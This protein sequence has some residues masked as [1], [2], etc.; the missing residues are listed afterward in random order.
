MHVVLFSHEINFWAIFVFFQ[1]F[2][3]FDGQ[4]NGKT[5]RVK[6][7][8]GTWHEAASSKSS[9]RTRLLP[10]ITAVKSLGYSNFEILGRQTKVA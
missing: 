7:R 10:Q 2:T 3:H 5:E 9:E 4:T 8:I 6:S 1:Y